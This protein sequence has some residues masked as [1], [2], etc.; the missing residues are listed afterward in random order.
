MPT[1]IGMENFQEKH[2][3]EEIGAARK[4]ILKCSAGRKLGEDMAHND[5]YLFI[6]IWFI[7]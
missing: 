7:Y 3:F 6:Y 2:L 1:A 4:M 5:I